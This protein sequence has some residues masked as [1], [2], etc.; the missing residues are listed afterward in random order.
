MRVIRLGMGGKDVEA[1]LFFLRGRSYYQLEVGAK[2]DAQAVQATQLWQRD[3]GIPAD[4]VVGPRTFGRA[5]ELGF[6]P[7]F[8]DDDHSDSGPNWPAKPAFAALDGTARGQL[9]G[10]FAFKPA[11]VAGNPE[12]IEILDGWAM[13]NIELVEIPQLLGVAGAPAAAK[14]RLHKAASEPFRKFF[15]AVDDA[16]LKNRLRS[17][18]G[19]WAP[20]FIRGSRL[21]LSNH[22]YG[23]A[24]D[25]NVECNALAT[26][27]AHKG[28][29]GC[30]REL[31]PLANECGIY[32]GGHFARQEGMHFELARVVSG[33]P[34]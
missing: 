13:K 25:L 20:R 23:A 5:Q 24:I 19:S 21:L 2:F 30:V 11:P 34:G 3:Y 12:G 15:R 26:V 7:G 14:I 10:Q 16:G 31:V 6:N 22:A 28:S 32:W 4:G 9:F 18:G 27:P 1:W 17:F 8:E 33:G 29:T